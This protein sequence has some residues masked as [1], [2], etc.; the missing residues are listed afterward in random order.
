MVEDARTNSLIVTDI[1]RQFPMIENAIARLDVPIP[2]ILIEVEMLDVS[3]NTLDA[4]GVT[5]TADN[6]LTL[7]AKSLDFSSA[8]HNRYANLGSFIT[9]GDLTSGLKA[10]LAL[11]RNDGNT[12]TLAR[13]RV[14]TLDNQM[15]Q[16]K[17]ATDE[18]IGIKRNT[19]GTTGD[20]T[21]DE[22]ERLETGVIFTVT[23]QANLLLGEITLAIVPRVIDSGLTSVLG[24][25]KNPEERSVNALIKVKDGQTVIIGGLLRQQ[26]D[27]TVSKLPVLGDFPLLGR[28]FRHKREE[29]TTRDLLIVL[30]PHILGIDE[31]PKGEFSKIHGK[32]GFHRE[33]LMPN[34]R[35]TAIRNDLDR[36]SASDGE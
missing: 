16:I 25:Y 35:A 18:V 6:V 10:V 33:Q 31:I 2:Q 32:S 11:V 17:I 24:N 7:D 28:L 22:A 9:K 29:V 20:N 12:K 26:K 5:F 14:L 4:I 15:A 8:T 19:T 3:Q 21:T 27:M 30:T 34:S 36:I 13:P 1:P 23:P